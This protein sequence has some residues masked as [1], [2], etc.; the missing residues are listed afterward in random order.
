MGNRFASSYRM[1]PRSLPLVGAAP[2][3]NAALDINDPHGKGSLVSVSAWWD[4]PVLPTFR[5]TAY[6]FIGLIEAG[7]ALCGVELLHR[8]HLLLP[9]LYSWGLALPDKPEEAFEEVIHAYRAPEPDLEAL[10]RYQA[11]WHAVFGD[12][13][14]RLEAGWEHYQEVFDP[15]ADPSEEPVIGSLADDLADIYMDLMA[16]EHHWRAGNYD[17]A[18]WEWRFRFETHWSEHLTG[19][20]R[21]IRTLAAE[22]DV[23][24]PPPF[25]A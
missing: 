9:P 19:A 16:G 15:Y 14:S 7:S 1:W 8:V 5:Q 4:V 22:R 2:Q 13:Q 18:V 23:G 20:L 12:L 3:L 10:D 11:R 21:A 24:F 6:D 25:S 17:R